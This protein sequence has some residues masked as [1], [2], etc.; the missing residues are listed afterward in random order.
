MH[1]SSRLTRRLCQSRTSWHGNIAAQLGTGHGR[2]IYNRISVKDAYRAVGPAGAKAAAPTLSA[3]LNSHCSVTVNSSRKVL[4]NVPIASRCNLSESLGSPLSSQHFGAPG[5]GRRP[6]LRCESG[7][8]EGSSIASGLT[9]YTAT[10]K[11]THSKRKHQHFFPFA[12]SGRGF[13]PGR[14]SGSGGALLRTSR[15]TLLLLRQ[16]AEPH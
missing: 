12:I 6:T 10:A 15:I 14:S 11:P 4:P 8:H 7:N 2:A 3:P 1:L 16:D 13:K 5:F 9:C